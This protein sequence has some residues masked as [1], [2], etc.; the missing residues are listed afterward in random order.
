MVVAN[1]GRR[2]RQRGMN[3]IDYLLLGVGITCT[4]VALG[5]FRIAGNDLIFLGVAAL[6]FYFALDGVKAN[7]RDLAAIVLLLMMGLLIFANLEPYAAGAY[8]LFGSKLPA[9]ILSAIPLIGGLWPYVVGALFLAPILFLEVY[10]SILK[11]TRDSLGRTIA[12]LKQQQAVSP[13]DPN[14][15][16]QLAR[17]EQEYNNFALNTY[18]RFEQFRTV[19]YLIDFVVL[20]IYYPPFKEGWA[21]FRWGWPRIE[22][23]DFQHIGIALIILFMVQILVVGYIWIRNVN[24]IFIQG[25]NP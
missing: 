8:F 10:P 17:L 23:L 24:E 19:A 7:W 12:I 9:K 21:A 25:A 13:T 16:I 11:G 22:D 4:V 3:L 20:E 5:D 2:P 1:F 15:P 6:A 14:I 18:L